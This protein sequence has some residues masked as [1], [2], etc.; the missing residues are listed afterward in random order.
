MT[1]TIDDPEALK[2]AVRIS[3]LTGEKLDAVVVGALKRRFL[4]VQPRRE[5]ASVEEM[6]EMARSIREKIEGPYIDHGEL[7]YDEHG[8]PK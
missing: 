5:R 4:E 8:L 6:M 1:I 3:E 2:L 7:L